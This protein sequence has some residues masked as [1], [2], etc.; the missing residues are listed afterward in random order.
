MNVTYCIESVCFVA[1]LL[2][3]VAAAV[4]QKKLTIVVVVVCQAIC[5]PV[6]SLLTGNI[7]P[8]L[9]PVLTGPSRVYTSFGLLLCK[10]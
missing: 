6:V 3:I 2:C 9:F 8:T 10:C 7:N 5:V 1:T 4:T